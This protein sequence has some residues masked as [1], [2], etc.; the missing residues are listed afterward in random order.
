M[1]TRRLL[2][3]LHLLLLLLHLLLLHHHLAILATDIRPGGA[4]KASKQSPHLHPPESLRIKPSQEPPHDGT[5]REKAR[6]GH[7]ADPRGFLPMAAGTTL[8]RRTH[9][10]QTNNQSPPRDDGPRRRQVQDSAWRA[11]PMNAS[12][13]PAIKTDAA[14]DR[15]GW[16]PRPRLAALSRSVG[17]W[18]FA[19]A[20]DGM[21]GRRM[22]RWIR[23]SC[24]D[25]DPV[26]LDG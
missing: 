5:A 13:S 21:F 2:L 22:A 8:G 1:S 24:S 16:A 11:S 19:K 6:R 23:N 25:I 10:R 7:H 4:R 3:L 15:R 12:T 18:V 20:G 14:E 26:F 17:I 9:P